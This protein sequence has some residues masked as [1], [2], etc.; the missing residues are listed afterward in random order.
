MFSLIGFVVVVIVVAI[1]VTKLIGGS[2]LSQATQTGAAQVRKGIWTLWKKDPLAI[3]HQHLDN[4][5]ADLI[6]ARTG[7]VQYRTTLATISQSKK[8]SEDNVARLDARLRTAVEKESPEAEAL[9]KRLLKEKQALADYTKTYTDASDEYDKQVHL[10]QRAWAEVQAKEKDMDLYGSRLELSRNKRDLA[11]MQSPVGGLTSFD[12]Y[13]TEVEHEL[14]KQIAAGD[15]VLS[16]DKDL[17]LHTE[18]EKDSEVALN[19]DAKKLLEQYRMK[20]V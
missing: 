15:A 10:V 17:G 18:E 1:M 16:V 13:F 14:D 4:A 9:A 19:E 5:K 7:L 8:V 3:Y 11:N 6:K 12:N 20:S 2:S